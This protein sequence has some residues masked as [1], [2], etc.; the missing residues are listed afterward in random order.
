MSNNYSLRFTPNKRWTKICQIVSLLGGTIFILGL[1]FAP[2]R[3]WPNVLLANYY[4]LSLGLAGIFFVALQYVSNAG[5]SAAIR[6]VPE[7]MSSVL[8]ISALIMLL[9][10]FG[11]HTLYE[12]S[13]ESVVAHDHLLQTKSGWLNIPFFVGR[14][15]LY[16]GLWI[17][18]TYF[19]VRSSR[20]QDDNGDLMFTQ[21]N[22]RWSAIFIVV[23]ALTFSLACFDW[24]MSI[25][26]HWYS[27]IFA[28]YNFSGLFLNG[29]A[30]LTMIIILL[31][32]WSVLQGV[33]TE[34]HLH[35]LG[36]LIFAFATFWMYIW[37]SQYLL[38]WYANIPEEVVYFTRR[39]SGSWATF[40]VLNVVF[41]WVLPFVMLLSSKAKKNEGL[42]FKVCII[43][44][45]GHWIDLFWMILPPFMNNISFLN[46]WEIGP[47][48]GAVALFFLV[49]FKTLSKGN[50]IPVND[51][52]LIES[53]NYHS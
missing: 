14:I 53:L 6:R 2:E 9:T 27:T 49:T 33:I 1:F 43:V 51:P 30:A 8:P 34:S 26:P 24:I 46:V 7:A 15:I 52:Y 32:R 23:F 50:V 16:F 10:I 37:F 18:C 39:E 19:I 36:K 45:I 11:F 25:E 12:W 13:H 28:V 22:V 21:R 38:I 48:A 40:S 44:M 47:I 5:W 42:L 35:D 20:K 3:I 4:L 31:R 41:N 29:L 17:A